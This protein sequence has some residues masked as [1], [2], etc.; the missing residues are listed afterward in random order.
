MSKAKYEKY[1]Q[2][3]LIQNPKIKSGRKNYN[4]LFERIKKQLLLIKRFK[5]KIKEDKKNV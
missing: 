5:K 3:I 1:L 2:D 4:F